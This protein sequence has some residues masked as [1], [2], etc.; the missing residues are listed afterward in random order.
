M[1]IWKIS[2]VYIAFLFM[3]LS[4]WKEIIS[5]EYR[6]KLCRFNVLNYCLEITMTD[7]CKIGLKIRE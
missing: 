3:G 5:K 4:L 1:N 6:V 7:L 2:K